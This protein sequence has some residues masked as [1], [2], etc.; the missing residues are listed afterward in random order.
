MLRGWTET[1]AISQ[2]GPFSFGKV[3]VRPLQ[4]QCY[5]HAPSQRFAR[6]IP[7]ELRSKT[8]PSSPLGSRE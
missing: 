8:S 5:R 7:W 3:C 2:K 4:T 6:L 1:I